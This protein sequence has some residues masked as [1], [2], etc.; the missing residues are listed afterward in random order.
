MDSEREVPEKLA[1]EPLPVDPEECLDWDFDIGE[2]PP[3]FARMANTRPVN[4]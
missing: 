3:A 2:R 1:L 4:S